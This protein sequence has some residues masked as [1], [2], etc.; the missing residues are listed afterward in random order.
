MTVDEVIAVVASA[1]LP[2]H[3]VPAYATLLP[4]YGEPST[5]RRT[6]VNNAIIARWDSATMRWILM[7]AWEARESWPDSQ[8]ALKRATLN[9]PPRG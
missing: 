1:K 7:Q 8:E 4:C 3:V 6:A 2:A 5:I 9:Q